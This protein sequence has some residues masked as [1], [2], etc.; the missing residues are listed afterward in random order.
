MISINSL[1]LKT[2]L[3]FVC[4]RDPRKALTGFNIRN[5]P[6]GGAI[7]AGTNWTTLIAIHDKKAIVPEKCNITLKN[8][9]GMKKHLLDGSNVVIRGSTLNIE[10]DKKESVYSL[11]G[12]CLMS[13]KFPNYEH[14]LDLTGFSEG[15][16]GVFDTEILSSALSALFANQAYVS[17]FSSKDEPR[18][19]FTGK[20]NGMEFIGAIMS[21]KYNPII[22][23]W[24]PGGKQ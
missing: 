17:F 3:P 22:P 5:S 1:A 15:I 13:D 14:F 11:C 4:A 2:V 21:V 7:I 20:T 8:N 19:I 12:D 9:K 23:D 6:K 10:N 18:I 16:N 24:L